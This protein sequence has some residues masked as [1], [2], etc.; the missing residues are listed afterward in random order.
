MVVGYFFI[1]SNNKSISDLIKQQKNSIRRRSRNKTLTDGRG[2]N[3][4]DDLVGAFSMMTSR[5]KKEKLN[6]NSHTKTSNRNHP[7]KMTDGVIA[8]DIRGHVLHINHAA[9]KY[10]Y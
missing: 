2:N 7:I 6:R 1:K 3:E 10:S 8:F 5:T 9:K 4:I